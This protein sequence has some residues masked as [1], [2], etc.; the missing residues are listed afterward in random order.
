MAEGPKVAVVELVGGHGGMY[1]YD[2]G[3]CKGLLSAG[4]RVSLY[5][6]SETKNPD[7]L[8]LNFCPV[9]NGI[10]GKSSPALRAFRFLTG[11]LAVALSTIRRKETIVHFHVFQGGVSEFSLVLLMRL[12]LRKIVLTVHDV[13]SLARP[14]LLGKKP[15]NRVYRMAEC[16]IVH[17]ETSKHELIERLKLDSGRINVIPHGNYLDAISDVPCAAEAKPALAVSDTKK[18]ILFFGQIK[19]AK[20]LDLLIE[21][22]PK[23]VREVP[24]TMLVIAGRPSRTDFS[25][26]D[27]LID[28]LGLRDF[29]RADVGYVPDE[30]VSQYY[31]AA[32][33]VVLPYRRI[34]QS[35]VLLL[36][37]SYGKAVVVSDIPAMTEIVADGENGYL[38]TRESTEDL[39]KTLVRALQGDRERQEIGARALKY[40]RHRHDWNQ[41]GAETH[42]VYWTM[43]SRRP[44][45]FH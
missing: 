37:M 20:G 45:P 30:K 21:A 8:G 43:L 2:I 17:N 35:G 40:V 39:A 15:S 31:A 22:L 36:A 29:C 5:T 18:V 42:Q 9:Y 11:S 32:D 28:K 19:E 38:F 1:H 16:L 41:I 7:I 13:E 24:E 6:C 25:Q 34:Y 10:F 14:T 12:C 27:L 4:V 23:V 3:L 33:V 26:Y 44:E